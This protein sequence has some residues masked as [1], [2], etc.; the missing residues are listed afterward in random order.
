MRRTVTLTA[1]VLFGLLSIGLYLIESEVEQQHRRLGRLD[2]EMEQEQKNL[3]VLRAEWSY[4]NQ[5]ERLQELAAAH[6]DR[7]GLRPIAPAQIGRLD[8]LP[9]R[10]EPPD[11]AGPAAGGQMAGLPRPAFK[12]APPPG[13]VFAS[14]GGR[15]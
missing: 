11:E 12:P 5:P 7:V 1:L 15:R 10:P 13:V 14:T 2:A 6:V 9:M 8:E 3:Q 4:L